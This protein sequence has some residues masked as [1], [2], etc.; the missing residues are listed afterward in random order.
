MDNFYT[1]YPALL[2]CKDAID[3]AIDAIVHLPDAGGKLLLCGNGGSSADCDH[4][5]GELMKGFLCRR[6]L[7][8]QDRAR[9]FAAGMENAAAFA[10]SLQYG[11][12]A[13]SLPAQTALISAYNNDVNADMVYAQMV[14]VYG[15]PEDVLF[16]ISTSGNSVNVTNAVRAAQVKG[17]T[18]IGLTGQNTCALSHLC[19]I[20]IHAPETQTYRIQE[21]HLPIYHY[22][23]MEVE[24]RLWSHEGN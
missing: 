16:A 2:R 3:Q 13:I 24:R 19:T 5:V 17:M 22:I 18:T 14:F 6:P 10:E 23:C 20:T 7:A 12:P 15:R 4:I 21:Y 9:F 1:R 11:I 8:A